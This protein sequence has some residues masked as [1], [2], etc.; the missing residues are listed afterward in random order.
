MSTQKTTGDYKIGKGR[1]PEDTRWKPGQS[2]NPKGRPKAAKCEPT[3]V[4]AILGEPLTVKTAGT[5][6]R[7]SPFEVGVRQLAKRA[8]SKND[9]KAIL[10]FVRLCERYGIM[11]PL[12]P[13]ERCGRVLVVPKT[14]DWDEWLEVFNEH[15]PPPWPGERS[16]LPD[17]CGV[18]PTQE[19]R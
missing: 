3:D 7:M 9:L 10:E 14:W 1:P 2:G 11:V 17:E 8:L 12:P 13:P 4:V 5:T 16:G 15:G 19:G 6:Q 18:G